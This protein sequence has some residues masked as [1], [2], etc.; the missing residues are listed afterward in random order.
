MSATD[1]IPT[2]DLI[3]TEVLERVAVIDRWLPGLDR[4]EVA[5]ART[6]A[7]AT[8]AVAW[9]SV[10]ADNKAATLSRIEDAIDGCSDVLECLKDALA[11]NRR[12]S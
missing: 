1:Q 2:S 6:L 8:L 5:H 11:A 12:I 9:L 4:G 7:L 3:P 10:V